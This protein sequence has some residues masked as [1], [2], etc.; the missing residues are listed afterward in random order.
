MID[1]RGG[2]GTLTHFPNTLKQE[3]KEKDIELSKANPDELKG[4]KKTVCDNFLIVLMLSGANGTKY[5][6]LKQSMKEC[7]DRNKHLP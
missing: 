7:C 5:N 1:E 3:L 6:D 4:G 2:P